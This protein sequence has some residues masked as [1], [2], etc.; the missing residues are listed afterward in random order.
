MATIAAGVH[1]QRTRE[2]SGTHWGLCSMTPLRRRFLFHRSQTPENVLRLWGR[3]GC[4]SSQML[5]RGWWP[6]VP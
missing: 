2:V 6:S 3:S 5:L 1:A 4:V